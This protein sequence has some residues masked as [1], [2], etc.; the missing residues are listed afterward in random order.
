MSPLKKNQIIQY[1]GVVY[2]DN[3]KVPFKV[4][5]KNRKG[6]TFEIKVDKDQV[7]EVYIYPAKKFSDLC[8]EE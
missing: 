5:Y 8:K 2:C 6:Q 4:S 7:E 1:K 3:A